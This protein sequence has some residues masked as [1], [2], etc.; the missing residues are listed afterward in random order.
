MFSQL[1]KQAP[2]YTSLK[3][4]GAPFRCADCNELHNAKDMYYCFLPNNNN[5]V[6]C[7]TCLDDT[8]KSLAKDLSHIKI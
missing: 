7:K 2:C 8:W 5:A 6:V 1:Q 4:D 3:D